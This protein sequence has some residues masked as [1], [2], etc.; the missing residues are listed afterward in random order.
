[1]TTSD[2][3]FGEWHWI[4]F[5]GILLTEAIP[6]VKLGPMDLNIC[7]GQTNTIFLDDVFS[8]AEMH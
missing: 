5:P 1:M 4:A 7:L 8:F 2:S 3:V 6:Y